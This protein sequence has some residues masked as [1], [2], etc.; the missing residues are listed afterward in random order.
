MT[1]HGDLVAP[2]NLTTQVAAHV[3]ATFGDAGAH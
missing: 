2:D 3:A 1:P